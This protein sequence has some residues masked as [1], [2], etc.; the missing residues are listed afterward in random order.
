MKSDPFGLDWSKSMMTLI[1][2]SKSRLIVLFGLMLGGCSSVPSVFWSDFGKG[3]IS[4]NVGS[5]PSTTLATGQQGPAG[6]AGFG[7]MVYWANPGDGT[8][9]AVAIGGG[10]PKVLINGL[11][12]PLGLAI[13]PV[14]GTLFWTNTGDGTIKSFSVGDGK[15][16]TIAVDQMD[17]LNIVVDATTV[18]WTDPGR[19]TVMSC[20]K[21][22]CANSSPRTLWSGTTQTSLAL[23][24]GIAVDATNVYWTDSLNRTVNRTPIGGGDTT[25][26]A[27]GAIVFANPAGIAVDGNNVYW[28]NAGNGGAV[29]RMTLSGGNPQTLFVGGTPYAIGV[30]ANNVYWISYGSPTSRGKVYQVAKTCNAPCTPVTIANGINPAAISVVNTTK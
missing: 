9:N 8:I 30:N 13:D 24:W 26:L 10:V 25:I 18:Y 11:A 1:G 28:V 2:D 23:P 22:G 20:P 7:S 3:T 14:A 16:T 12:S 21:A 6:I 17:P 4:R 15:L 5:G 27:Q 19:G 29:N